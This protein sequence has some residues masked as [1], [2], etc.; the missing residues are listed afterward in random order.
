M[1]GRAFLRGAPNDGSFGFLPA[2]LLEQNAF[3][4][5]G[6]PLHRGWI[7][8]KVNFERRVEA[9]GD[10]PITAIESEGRGLC[11]RR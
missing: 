8:F 3:A 1:S 9:H 11:G 7:D 4:G 10:A 6:G 5:F 2:A